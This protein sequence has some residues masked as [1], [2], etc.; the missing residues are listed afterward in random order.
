MAVTVRPMVFDDI[1]QVLHL[2]QL[3][4]SRSPNYRGFSFSADQACRTLVRAVTDEHWFAC[5]AE[6][7]TSNGPQIVGFVLGTWYEKHFSTDREAMDMGVFTPFQGE[8]I[9]RRLIEAYV[10]WAK[11][12]GVKR[13]MVSVEAGLD[14]E[15]VRR[16]LSGCGFTDSGFSMAYEG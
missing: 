4:H 9:G 7:G 2:A 12:Q 14:P 11:S 13:I 8:G 10:D 1:T 15:P 16:A 5:V 3:F 6:R